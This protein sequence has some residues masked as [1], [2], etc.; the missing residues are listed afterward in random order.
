MPNQCQID[1]SGFYTGQTAEVDASSPC[2][3]GWVWTDAPDVED[4][5]VARWINGAWAV[6]ADT[7]QSA[8]QLVTAQQWAVAGLTAYANALLAQGYPTGGLHVGLQDGDR[9]NLTALGT[10]AL[11]VLSSVPGAEWPTGYATG[12]IAL[13]GVHIT[14]PTAQDGFVLAMGCGA[15]YSA[16]V[17][18]EAALETA[19][20]TAADLATLQAIDITTG[21]PAGA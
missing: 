20:L 10:T 16:W 19:I 18:R 8:N 4:G 5:S 15:Y 6:V 21:W 17:Q 14:L 12:W 3:V 2:P 7:I 11:A 1:G 9:A 13:E